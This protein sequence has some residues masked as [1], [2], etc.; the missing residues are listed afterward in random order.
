MEQRIK[1]SVAAGFDNFIKSA[2]FYRLLVA[3]FALLAVY[4]IGYICYI[5]FFRM[6]DFISMD[7]S[8]VLNTVKDVVRERTLFPSTVFGEYGKDVTMSTNGGIIFTVIPVAAVFYALTGNIFLSVAIADTIFTAVILCLFRAVM[9]KYNVTL[10]CR[11]AGVCILLSGYVAYDMWSK[12]NN[13]DYLFC[14]FIVAAFYSSKLV[15]TFL[16][17]LFVKKNDDEPGLLSTKIL[18]IAFLL[19]TLLGSMDQ[20]LYY[21][22]MFIAPYFVY[23]AVKAFAKNDI[24][25][26]FRKKNIWFYIAAVCALLG[27]ALQGLFAGDAMS[28][29]GMSDGLSTMETFFANQN[30]SYLYLMRF[31]GAVPMMGSHPV[32]SPEAIWYMINHFI[33]LGLL[34]LFAAYIV[35]ALKQKAEG[36]QNLA[37]PIIV[38]VNYIV[39]QFSDVLID[40]FNHTRYTFTAFLLIF[41][42]AVVQLNRL[43]A[44]KLFTRVLLVFILFGVAASSAGT[45]F[46]VNYSNQPINKRIAEVMS[47]ERFDD[48]GVAYAFGYYD[49]PSVLNVLDDSREYQSILDDRTDQFEFNASIRGYTLKEDYSRAELRMAIDPDTGRIRFYGFN[50][51]KLRPESYEGATVI[52]TE[53]KYFENFPDY[54]KRSYRE[55]EDT[56]IDYLHFYYSDYDWVNPDFSEDSYRA[57]IVNASLSLEDK[58]LTA[59][60]KNI[61]KAP[62]YSGIG[63]ELRVLI[64]DEDAPRGVIEADTSILE[65]ETVRFEVNSDNISPADKVELI[66]LKEGEFE[67]GNR[68][69]LR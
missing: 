69:T 18:G 34:A 15:Y 9:K 28:G 20:S 39:F 50:Y 29:R 30:R 56:A 38:G 66:M 47:D 64:N 62:W 8:N 13:L 22:V 51:T 42:C 60:V 21:A 43:K 68:I 57:E 11:L 46:H 53:P 63:T 48:I 23:M 41:V 26:I 65:G 5:N 31:L 3:A 1:P 35:K 19:L 6:S 40:Q 16:F 32:T 2:A 36:A 59:E 33:V 4:E 12:G 49:I 24:G 61:G 44:E 14:S 25:E 58:M 67:F 52:I 7:S 10:L 27:V 17:V 54:I 45:S 55:A 37:F